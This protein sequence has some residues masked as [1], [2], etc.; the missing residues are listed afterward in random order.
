M[1]ASSPIA[2]SVAVCTYERYASLKATLAAL[3]VQTGPADQREILVLDNS[4]DRAL[5]LRQQAELGAFPGLRWFHLDQPGVA[6][7]RNAA[8]NE[9]RGKLLA[10]VDDDVT[11]QPGWLAALLD[12]F[13]RFGDDAHSAGGPVRPDWSAPPPPWL[14]EGMLPFLSLVDRGPLARL[15]AHDEW[16]PAANAAFRLDRLQAAGGFCETLGRKGDDS[17]LLSNEDTE[18]MNRLHRAGGHTA[19]LPSAAVL[20][21]ISAERLDQSWF[22]RR[23]AWQ[24]ISDF[25]VQPAHHRTHAAAS[26]RE[27]EAYLAHIGT[28]GFA[29]LTAEQP[30]ADLCHWQMS[31]IYHLLLGL[32]SGAPIEDR[33][34]PTAKQ[35]HG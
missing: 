7:A 9:A 4:P 27:A 14:A 30:R 17:N 16:I 10:F 23:F 22:R 21:R 34:S 31:A 18:L 13:S 28:P 25:M 2:I 19:W 29:A 1:I 20:H 32:L 8:T 3:R 15:L 24:A 11:P 12:G 33:E 26:W 35:P 6:H 5:S